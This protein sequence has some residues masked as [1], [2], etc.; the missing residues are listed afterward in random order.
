MTYGVKLRVWGD[1]A[2]FTRPEL[3]AERV[4]YEVMTPSA[5]RGVLEAIHWKP[6]IR[7]V[8]DAIHALSPI[9][10]QSIR[11][12]ELGHKAPVGKIKRA[13]QTA[14]LDGLTIDVTKDRQ[15]RHTNFLVNVD[16]IIAAHF[17]MTARAGPTDTE[18]KHLDM[19]HRRARR[20]QSF[21]QPSLGMREF[22]AHFEP[23][24][25]HR[26][27]PKPTC[28]TADLGFG[29][30]RELGLMLLD[31]DYETAHRPPLFFKA[32]LENGVMKV[33]HPSSQEVYR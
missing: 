22:V 27:L 2:C 28:A 19:F 4:S 32:N 31:I 6:E 17:E 15:Q 12:N 26:P 8:I 33:P 1:R 25:P 5:A 14:T 21:H 18:G 3:K 10:F 29:Q 20:G 7:W 9:R 11:R 23:L 13:F 16:Y 24:D 30:K